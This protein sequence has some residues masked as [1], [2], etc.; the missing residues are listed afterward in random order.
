M[1][2]ILISFFMFNNKSYLDKKEFEELC[3]EIKRQDRKTFDYNHSKI[4]TQFESFEKLY[5]LHINVI[6]AA[7]LGYLFSVVSEEVIIN[8]FLFFL[9]FMFFAAR[10]EINYVLPRMKARVDAYDVIGVKKWKK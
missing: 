8:K 3:E 1:K 2:G 10:L 7:A 4:R 6:L 9:I 5:D